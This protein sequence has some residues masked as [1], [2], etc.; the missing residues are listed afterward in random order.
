M[1]LWA[2]LEGA[3]GE[4]TNIQRE[5]REDARWREKE[6]FL[7]DLRK[8]ERE[9]ERKYQEGR[10][11]QE[12]LEERDGR[13]MIVREN[14]R[15]EEISA[16][17]ATAAEQAQFEREGKLGDLELRGAEARVG[18]AELG[19][20]TDTDFVR[21][22]REQG[23]R[24]AGLRDQLTLAQIARLQA[25]QAPTVTPDNLELSSAQALRDLEE[26]AAVMQE[27]PKAGGGTYAS[28]NEFLAETREMIRLVAE[29][30]GLPTQAAKAAATERILSLRR[31]I[32]RRG[33][34]VTG[35]APV[36]SQF[37][38]VPASPRRPAPG[39]N[40]RPPGGGR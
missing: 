15:G 36:D 2:F 33:T 7:A 21:R 5:G 22:E 11:Q 34:P 29:D 38:P 28:V 31:E 26:R 37:E 16:R 24:S 23:L 10:V 30:D 1:S 27:I 4:Y 9:D 25:E 35:P 6:Q 18:A 39:V 17:A 40:T 14:N 32:I 20:E 13:L 19:L 12:R 3:S 8:G